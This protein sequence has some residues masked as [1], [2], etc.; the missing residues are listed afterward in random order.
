MQLFCEARELAYFTFFKTQF[1]FFKNRFMC[2]TGSLLGSLQ[3]RPFPFF[4]LSALL[5]NSANRDQKVSF[6]SPLGRW[7]CAPSPIGSLSKLRRQRQR[8]RHQTKGLMS[9]TIALHV[10]LKSWYISLSFSAKQQREMTKFCVF[11]TT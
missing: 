3:R 5:I 10:R 7:V 8:E 2:F 9:R 11:W 1:L 6:L 4:W